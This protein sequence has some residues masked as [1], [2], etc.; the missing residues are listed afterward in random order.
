MQFNSKT[1]AELT[2]N[3]LYDILK[4]RET[5]FLLEQNIICQDIDDKDKESLHCFLTDNDKLVAYLRAYECEEGIAIGRVLSLEH[6]KGLGRELLLKSMDVIKE[7][8]N[9]QS[10]YAHAQK[11]AEGFYKKLG[12][13]TISGEYL[14]E[15]VVHV[16]MTKKI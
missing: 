6:K 12:F 15:G 8:F 5:I 11:Q 9:C 14:E 4:A 7:H 1:F 13:E 10:I 16:T 3:E 2:V